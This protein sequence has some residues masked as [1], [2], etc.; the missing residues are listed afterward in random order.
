M[1]SVATSVLFGL[2]PVLHA[3]RVDLS[4]AARQGGARGVA[5]EISSRAR[6]ALVASEIAL[7]ALL[8][9]GAGC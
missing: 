6:G 5:G 4:H 1:R 7:A 9:T 2:V 8:L 3:S